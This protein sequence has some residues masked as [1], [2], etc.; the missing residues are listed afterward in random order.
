MLKGLTFFGQ[1]LKKS[2]YMLSEKI[3]RQIY[4]PE[5]VIKPIDSAFNI[6]LLENGEIGYSAKKIGYYYNKMIVNRVKISE[7]DKPFLVDLNFITLKRSNNE[8]KSLGY[9]IVH[10]LDYEEFLNAL[11]CVPKDY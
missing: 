9:S 8:V 2:V 10:K 3:E 11:R 6:Y 7:N 1:L 4:S 5:E